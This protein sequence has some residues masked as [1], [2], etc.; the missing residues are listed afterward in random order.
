MREGD[1]AGEG[2]FLDD[3]PH[4]TNAEALTDIEVLIMTKETLQIFKKE[5]HAVFHALME[6]IARSLNKRLQFS[7]S[8]V[9]GIEQIHCREVFGSSE[10]YWV[11]GMFQ[12]LLIMEY[13]P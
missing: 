9:A 10:T 2:L 13:K 4:S 3:S 1:F 7:G 12:M 5:K 11:S 8:I 6:W